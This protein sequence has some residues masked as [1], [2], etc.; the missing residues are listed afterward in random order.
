MPVIG[1]IFLSN[2]LT[3]SRPPADAPIATI[4]NSVPLGPDFSRVNSF[5]S[6]DPD[7]FIPTFFN[8]ADK[9]VVGFNFNIYKLF[10]LLFWHRRTPPVEDAY[11]LFS[12]LTNL[13]T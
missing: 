6:G 4:G 9:M 1:E 8:H 7:F 13:F 11:F 12:S 3:A 5:F 10:P 2:S